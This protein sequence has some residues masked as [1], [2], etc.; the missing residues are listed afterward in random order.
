MANRHKPVEVEDLWRAREAQRDWART[1]FKGPDAERCLTADLRERFALVSA[2]PRLLSDPLVVGGTPLAFVLIIPTKQR[3]RP[4]RQVRDRIL[5]LFQE[6]G[7]CV[8]EGGSGANTKAIL[9]RDDGVA[10]F[11][12]SLWLFDVAAYQ[13][14][15][16]D[17]PTVWVAG[18]HPGWDGIRDEFL[19][20][21]VAGAAMAYP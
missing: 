13:K 14:D 20:H 16:R 15:R 10:N 7:E 3:V 11:L 12:E 1:V 9:T 19:K 6:L 5:G 8:R 4:L 17:F 2:E 21:Q 18:R